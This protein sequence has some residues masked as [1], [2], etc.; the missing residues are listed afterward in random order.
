MERRGRNQSRRGVE[1]PRC[2]GRIQARRDTP[3]KIGAAFDGSGTF[4]FGEPRRFTIANRA[5]ARSGR[6]LVPITGTENATL[7]GDDYRVDHSHRLPGLALDG[8]LSG[9]INRGPAALSTVQGPAHAQI[10]DLAEAAGSLESLG[11][12]MPEITRR[13]HGP[14]DA[15]MTIAGT[16]RAPQVETRVSSEALDLP[17][18]G[19]VRA[20]AEVKANTREAS[21]AAIDVRQGTATVTGSVLADITNRTWDGQ[22]HVDAPNAEELQMELPERVARDWTNRCRRQT[23]RNLRQLPAGYHDRRVVP[24]VR[25][26]AT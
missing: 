26:P 3:Q 14:L 11:I 25:G 10:S 6:G 1:E 17:F 7:V 20:S 5:T 19:R 18:V 24:D 15:P 21:I 16:Y 9:R 8:R 22:L 12:A 23:R 2:P 13:I 4:E